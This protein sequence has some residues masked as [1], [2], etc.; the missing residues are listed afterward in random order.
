ALRQELGESADRPPTSEPFVQEVHRI[1][2]MSPHPSIPESHWDAVPPG[3]QAAILA[4][5]A[6]LE[7]RIADLEAR[8]NQNSTNS[9]TPRYTDPPPSRAQPAPPPSRAGRTRG[10]H[11]AHKRPPRTRAPPEHPRATFEVKPTH[12]GGCG[13]AIQGQDP[14]PVRPQAAEIPPVRPNV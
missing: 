14:A 4:V 9:S 13:A 11:P 3:A 12:C 7:A 8:L 6:S 2:C 5:I 1:C 10:S